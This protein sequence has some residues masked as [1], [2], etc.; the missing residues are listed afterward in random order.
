MKEVLARYAVPQGP[1]RCVAKLDNVIYRVGKEHCLRVYRPRTHTSDELRSILSWL[2][3]LARDSE[4]IAPRPLRNDAGELLTITEQ[5][6]RCA[7]LTW[8]AGRMHPDRPRGVHFE[9]QGGMMAQLHEHAKGWT[10]PPGFVVPRWDAEGICG[11]DGFN[12]GGGDPWPHVPDEARATLEEVVEFARAGMARA[13]EPDMLIHADLHLHNVVFA[14]GRACAID[15]DDTGYGHAEYD[16]VSALGVHRF[17]DNYDAVLGHFERG[18]GAPAGDL[19]PFYAA[20]FAGLALWIA[21][22][23]QRPG[24]FQA[25]W[26]TYFDRQFDRARRCLP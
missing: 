26:R 20:R 24:D 23:G 3:A 11:T 25:Q 19:Q 13:G 5:G 4:V 17:R 22:M 1:I 8:V 21:A 6:T 9:R 16:W 12:D 7:L 14:R 15:F 10:P 18:Y 2:E